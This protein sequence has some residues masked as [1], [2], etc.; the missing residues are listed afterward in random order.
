MQK[1]FFSFIYDEKGSAIIIVALGMVVFL[2]LVSLVT[3]VGLVLVSKS[4]LIN[5]VDSSALAG[6]QDLPDRP[7]LAVIDAQ[8]YAI[9][10][11]V[12]I[13][14]LNIEVINNDKAIIVKAGRNVNL[15]FARILGINTGFVKHEA[16][17]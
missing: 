2:G 16:M 17:A 14:D 1:K 6:A 7:D 10:N 5:G 11:G 3:D 12:N 13:N 4:K 9:S 8:N 15:F